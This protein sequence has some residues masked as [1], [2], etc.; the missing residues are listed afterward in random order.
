M[1]RFEQQKRDCF[2]CR[3]H[4]CEVAIPGGVIYEDD[5]VYAGHVKIDEGQTTAY[6]GH[7][8]VEPK[9]HIQGLEDLTDAE[10]QAL[11]MLLAR[12]SR[13][14]KIRE[15][16]EH[17]Y[18]F[19][20]GHHVPHLHIHVVPRY[21]G[22]PRRYWGLRVDEWPDAP[23]GGPQEIIALCERVRTHLKRDTPTK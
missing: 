15:K 5:L 7:L 21:R 18:A 3:K 17:V 12:L 13:A 14:L 4:R 8:F 16:V 10:A 9:R 1:N 11:G 6:L 2:I 22:T 19:V 23:R 20:L